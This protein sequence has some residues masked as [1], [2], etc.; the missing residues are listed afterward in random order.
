MGHLPSKAQKMLIMPWVPLELT[1]AKKSKNLH[2]ISLLYLI[3]LNESVR[4]VCE[5]LRNVLLH[6]GSRSELRYL[7]SQ[8]HVTQSFHKARRKWNYQVVC[9]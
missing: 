7:C 3:N 5:E 8:L 2:Q 1:D 9:F 4:N 6:A